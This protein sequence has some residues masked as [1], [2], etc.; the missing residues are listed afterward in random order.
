MLRV[1]GDELSGGNISNSW[2]IDYEFIFFGENWIEWI[3]SNAVSI[4]VSSVGG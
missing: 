1:S 3:E 4:H 2:H